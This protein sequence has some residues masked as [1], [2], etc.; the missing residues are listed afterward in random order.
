MWKT[1]WTKIKVDTGRAD[2]RPQER[3]RAVAIGM[4]EVGRLAEVK[5]KRT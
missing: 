2:R 5:T 3:N 1:D 4:K